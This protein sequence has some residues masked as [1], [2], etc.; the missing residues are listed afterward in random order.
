[1][2]SPFFGLSDETIFSLK[3]E[4]TRSGEIRTLLDTIT[5]SPPEFIPTEQQQQVRHAGRVLTE[6]RSQK[7]RWPLVRLFQYLLDQ[8]GYDASLLH[9]FMGGVKLPT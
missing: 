9:E 8:T 5:Q 4:P 6:L 7:D 3:Y 1:M 2:R